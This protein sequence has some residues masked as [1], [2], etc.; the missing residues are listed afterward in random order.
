MRRRLLQLIEVSS[1]SSCSSIFSRVAFLGGM[2][3]GPSAARGSVPWTE[4]LMKR[5]LGWIGRT[6][7]GGFAPAG[8]VSEPPLP[9]LLYLS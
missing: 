8:G 3:G 6:P 5:Y 1:S 7:L 4:C 9:S 2:R